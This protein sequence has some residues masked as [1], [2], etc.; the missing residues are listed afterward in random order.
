MREILGRRREREAREHEGMRWS[1]N[2]WDEPPAL[3]MILCGKVVREKR[4]GGSER[5]VWV[6]DG[7][8][9]V[10]ASIPTQERGH[11]M[12]VRVRGRE[13]GAREGGSEREVRER[14]HVRDMRGWLGR[15]G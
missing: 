9:R 11:E 14:G 1:L 13:K 7:C 12:E 8:G 4:D 3:A 15:V 5:D 2:T 6:Q 10:R